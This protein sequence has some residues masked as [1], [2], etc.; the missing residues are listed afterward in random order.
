M[1]YAPSL[2]LPVFVYRLGAVSACFFI[3]LVFAAVMMSS[4]GRCRRELS[5]STRD[6]RMKS[7]LGRYF[8]EVARGRRVPISTSSLL[9]WNTGTLS[10]RE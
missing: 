4:F 10:L 3:L 8:D 1:G 2:P 6:F 5:I 9:T 7:D